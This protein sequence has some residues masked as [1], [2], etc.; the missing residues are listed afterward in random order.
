M[1]SVRKVQNSRSKNLAGRAIPYRIVAL[2]QMLK[3]HPLRPG[4]AIS[5]EPILLSSEEQK[6]FFPQFTLDL[7]YVHVQKQ[8][9][10][11]SISGVSEWGI[12]WY[13]VDE[14]VPSYPDREAVFWGTIDRL[15]S[16]VEFVASAL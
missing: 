7:Y 2:E 16:V 13:R 12:F 6:R 5:I 4:T 11:F 10:I 9:R 8:G 14:G 3:N 15:T 1:H